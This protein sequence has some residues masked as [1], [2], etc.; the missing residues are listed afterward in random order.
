MN[1]IACSVNWRWRLAVSA[2]VV[3]GSDA[4]MGPTLPGRPLGNDTGMAHPFSGRARA[5]VA[6]LVVAVVFRSFKVATGKDRAT[7]KTRRST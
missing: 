2:S 6:L 4:D 7:V 5:T 3:T 1:S